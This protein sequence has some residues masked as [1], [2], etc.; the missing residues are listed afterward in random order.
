MSSS[1][2]ELGLEVRGLLCGLRAPALAPFLADWPA[3]PAQA[4]ALPAPAGTIPLHAPRQAPPPALP[5]LRWMADI[6]GSEEIFGAAA[7]LVENLCRLAQC[8][9]WRQTYAANEVGE[10][11]L[12][13]YAY[14][15]LLGR[16]APLPACHIASG[17]LLLGPGTRY[18]RHLHE[19]EE[20]YV[21]LCGTAL[22]QQGD[23]GWRERPPGTVIHH[24][25]HEPHAMHA[26]AGPLLALYVWRGKNLNQRARMESES[27]P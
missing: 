22:W 6:V 18:P 21:P 13:N 7:V 8:L 27:K 3:S 20:V 5:A 11:F 15:E 26:G 16:H 23:A 4:S 12:R 2:G 17:F 10:E 24:A 9:D 1:L 19:A 14:A 25:S